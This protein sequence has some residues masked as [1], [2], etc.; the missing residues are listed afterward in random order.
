MGILL[1]LTSLMR[2]KRRRNSCGSRLC[3]SSCAETGC[4]L[5][6]Q[7]TE[8]S[9]GAARVQQEEAR[10]QLAVQAEHEISKLNRPFTDHVNQ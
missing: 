7:P 1:S 5:T 3:S 10:D 4:L 9:V 2:A 6:E 8:C